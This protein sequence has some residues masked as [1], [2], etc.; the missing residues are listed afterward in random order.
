MAIQER[1]CH[2]WHIYL[3]PAVGANQYSCD[4]AH[5]MYFPFLGSM[6]VDDM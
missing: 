3:T 2:I 6:I 1:T 4:R 5:C